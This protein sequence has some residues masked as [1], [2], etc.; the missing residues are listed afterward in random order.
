MSAAPG[1][2]PGDDLDV[3]RAWTDIV[4]RWHDE[5][6][7]RPREREPEPRRTA[8]P[9]AAE[10]T[11]SA[12]DPSDEDED[13][14]PVDPPGWSR[15]VSWVTVVTVVLVAGP[16]V[17]LLGLTVFGGGVD[18]TRL[19]AAGVCFVAGMVLLIAR[20]GGPPDPDRDED[21]GAVV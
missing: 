10:S 16:P 18:Q 17:V 14:H 19:V 13:F 8:D 7:T 1:D 21:D 3:E 4:S 12:S 6:D 2:D 20:L 15:L 9:S 11:P 5:P